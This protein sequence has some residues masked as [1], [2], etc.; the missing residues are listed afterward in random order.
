VRSEGNDNPASW[1]V[2]GIW[3]MHDDVRVSGESEVKNPEQETTIYDWRLIEFEAVAPVDAN[4][5]AVFLTA[6]Y[7]GIVWYDD[8]VLCA[9]E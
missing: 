8:I 1:Y 7:H 9:L 3:W 5:A 4:R 6:H 2:I